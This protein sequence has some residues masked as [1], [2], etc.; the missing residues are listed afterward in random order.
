MP[1]GKTIA[2]CAL[3]HESLMAKIP[4]GMGCHGGCTPEEQLVPVMII[5]PNKTTATWRAVFKSFNVEEANPVVVY[6]I[7]GLDTNQQPL[8]E[9]DGRFYS[10]SAVGNTYTSE[11]LPL[12]KDVNKVKL[13]IGTWEKEEDTF[14]IR[15]AVQEDDLFTF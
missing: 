15:M 8:V 14:T 7:A 11:R 3:K 2:L 5:S 13:H 9:Y 6:E 12:N 1:D 4:D 10:M